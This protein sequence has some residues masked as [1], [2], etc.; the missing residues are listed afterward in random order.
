MVAFWEV[1]GTSYVSDSIIGT[2]MVFMKSFD[3][4]ATC[5]WEWNK[6]SRGVVE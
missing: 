1:P 6:R 3:G 5:E 2:L 4:D